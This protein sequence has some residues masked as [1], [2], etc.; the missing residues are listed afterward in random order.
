M[1]AQ[2]IHHPAT[3]SVSGL[4]GIQSSVSV[5]AESA[6]WGQIAR[7]VERR[8]DWLEDRQIELTKIPAPT[9]HEVLRAAY[10]AERFAGMGLQRVRSDEVGNVLAERS[11]ASRR[12]LAVTAHLDTVVPPGMPIEVRRSNGRIYAPGISDNG[13]GLAALLGMA[14]IL[15][16]C[17]ISTELSLLFVANVGEEGEGDLYGMRHLLASG[18][19]R[20][21]IAGMLILDGTAL[22]H[23][24]VAGLGSRRFLIEVSG[25]GGHSWKDFGRVNPINALSNVISQLA[26]VPLPAEP[27]TTLNVGTIQGGSAVNAIPGSAWMKLDIRSTKVEEIERVSSAVEAAVRSGVEQENQRGRGTLQVK[28]HAIGDRPAAELHQPSPVLDAVRAADRYLGIQSRLERS[29]TD[30][31]IPLALGMDAVSV[32]SGGSS[33]DAHTMNEWYDSQGRDLGLKRILLAVFSRCGVIEP[34]A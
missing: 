11:G 27:R 26:R 23:I 17:D 15:Q 10:M 2:L 20:E 18:E 25:P 24:T 22:D 3:A 32:G 21:R 16:E 28:M 30:A 9:F 14:A 19:M 1:R 31:N 5:I 4:A 6:I 29:S 7:S 33:G 13:A 12:C 34:S 8:R